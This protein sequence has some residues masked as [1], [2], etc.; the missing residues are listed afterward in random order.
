[1]PGEPVTRVHD[2]VVKTPLQVVN[3]YVDLPTAPGLGIELD[4]E[5]IAA[6]PYQPRDYPGAYW[7]DGGVADI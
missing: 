2:P 4:L 3:G 5:A 7:P 6:R 1:V